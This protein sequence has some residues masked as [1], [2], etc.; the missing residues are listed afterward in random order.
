MILSSASPEFLAL[1]RVLTTSLLKDLMQSDAIARK[2]ANGAPVMQ[3]SVAA[4]ESV[5]TDIAPFLMRT[6]YLYLL[7]QE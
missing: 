2:N 1:S 4:N 3:A 5:D 6:L 7:S